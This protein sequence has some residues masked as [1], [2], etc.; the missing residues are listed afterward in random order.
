CRVKDIVGLRFQLRGA[1]NGC[2]CRSFIKPAD[3]PK[4][5]GAIQL[6]IVALAWPR[7]LFLQPDFSTLTGFMNCFP[8]FID[9]FCD[10]LL[11]GEGYFGRINLPEKSQSLV[12]V[13]T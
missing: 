8:S 5:G 4:Q 13:A 2:D 12:H 7:Y 10:L 9:L 1:P 6:E 3:F 11:V